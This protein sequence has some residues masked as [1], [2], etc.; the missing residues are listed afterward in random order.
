MEDASA[1]VTPED[2]S[3]Q[4]VYVSQ[5]HLDGYSQ[6]VDHAHRRKEVFDRHVLSQTSKEVVF[7]AGDLVQVYRNDLE[8]TFKMERKLVPKFSAPRC[9]VS[10]NHNSYQ[11]QSLEGMPLPGWY[12]ARWLRPFIPRKGTE[13]EKV[14]KELEDR[15]REM[16]DKRDVAECEK[17][18]AEMGVEID[19]DR[20]ESAQD[21]EG[22]DG[23]EFEDGERD[24]STIVIVFHLLEL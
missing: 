6:M 10:R 19:V 24:E 5:Q 4:M 11:L 18:D 2:V 8:Y 23:V 1:E 21:A 7:R 20:C 22:R 15:W 16:E 13:L 9:V 3:L 12:H 17:S 14:Q